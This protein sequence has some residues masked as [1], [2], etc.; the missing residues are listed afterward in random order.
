MNWFRD[1]SHKA[2]SLE[3]IKR[4]ACVLLEKQIGFHSSTVRFSA[5]H[6]LD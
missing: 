2:L 6:L 5:D 3:H 4:L 1:F